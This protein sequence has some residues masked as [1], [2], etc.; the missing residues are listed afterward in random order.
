MQKKLKL[1]PEYHDRANEIYTVRQKDV[2]FAIKQKNRPLFK[3][4]DFH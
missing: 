4:L 2:N 1:P 3:Y